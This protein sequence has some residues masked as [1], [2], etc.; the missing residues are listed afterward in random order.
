MYNRWKK[1][2]CK[3]I[4]E[5]NIDNFSVNSINNDNIEHE[6]TTQSAHTIISDIY[7]FFNEV[8][9]CDALRV[10]SFSFQ[11]IFHILSF[12]LFL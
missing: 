10:L 12:H 11:C 9:R 5:C 7:E 6:I 8:F 1:S 4:K 3:L 2:R